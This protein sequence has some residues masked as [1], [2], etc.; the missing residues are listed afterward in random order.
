MNDGISGEPL[1]E[2][3]WINV[4]DY[5]ALFKQ[6]PACVLCDTRPKEGRGEERV[7]NDQTIDN[8]DFEASFDKLV[9]QG[10]KEV[11][12]NSELQRQIVEL[13]D[14]NRELKEKLYSLGAGSFQP[15]TLRTPELQNT[16]IE[17]TPMTL[18]RMRLE[19]PYH[20]QILLQH[21]LPDG[22][23]QLAH[24]ISRDAYEACLDKDAFLSEMV[25]MFVRQMFNGNDE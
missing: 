9:R 19:D 4:D 2:P 16:D 21:R 15:F 7:N 20:F 10:T 24:M 3:T 6:E 8:T 18:F 14:R 12:K 17:L 1:P 23:Y 5:E 13:E 25:N 22:G 11:I